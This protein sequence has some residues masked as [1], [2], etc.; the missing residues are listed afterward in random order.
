MVASAIAY[1]DKVG[2]GAA[3]ETFNELPDPEF[4][5]A[6]LYIF[7]V[8]ADGTT[9]AHAANPSRVGQNVSG[10]MDVEGTPFGAMFLEQATPEGAW[11]DYKWQD[12]VSGEIEPKS[13]WVV[14][15]DGHIFGCGVYK[16]E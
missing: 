4:R 14:L 3:F 5:R 13:S 1:Y 12:P 6:D 10:M 16:V 9:L 8:A 11:V 2:A 7:V 15:H